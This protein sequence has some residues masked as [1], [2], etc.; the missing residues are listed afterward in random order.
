M[1]GRTHISGGI[2]L[3][4]ILCNNWVDMSL[5]VI[6]SIISDID[7]ENSII[8]KSIPIIPKILK[9]RGIT[10]SLIFCIVG[11][12]I[13]RY[14]GLGILSHLVLDSFTIQ[15]IRWFYPISDKSLGIKIVRTGGILEKII[16]FL[17]WI[18]IIIICLYRGGIISDS[19]I[20]MSKYIR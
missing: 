4:S 18:M 1:Q 9:H 2:L 17:I 12:I 8:G 15:G 3:G 6:G 20:G 7:H 5:V 19:I 16:F 13:N 14:F 11:I 10:H